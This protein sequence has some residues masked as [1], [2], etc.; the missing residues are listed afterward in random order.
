MAGSEIEIDRA[1]APPK[2]LK[3][4]IDVPCDLCGLA[5][6]EPLFSARPDESEELFD[7]VR[8]RRCDLVYLDPAPAPE[9][10]GRWYASDYYGPENTKFDGVTEKAVAFFT[11]WRGL[12]L[13]RWAPAGGK[14]LDVGCGRGNFLEVMARRGYE[15]HGTELSGLSATRARKLFGPNIHVGQLAEAEFPEKT[16][17]LTTIW[18]VLE[19]VYDPLGHL[20]ELHRVLKDD[21]RLVVAVPNFGSIQAGFGGPSWFHLD[22]PRHLF[23]FT[24]Q[25]LTRLL[26][27]AGFEPVYWSFH[28]IEQ[29]PFGLLQTV[30]NKLP[31][32]QNALYHVLKM[33]T[34]LAL[35]KGAA[36][37][38][39][40]A[41]YFL[42]PAAIVLTSLGALIRR[43][44]T[45]YVVAKKRS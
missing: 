33:E 11:W 15:V 24:P 6:A 9:D 22:V 45:F 43:G 17:D 28:S 7:V 44:G 5:D 39:K 27:A 38:L 16:F 31:L 34:P 36:L 29:N 8:C 3:S 41:Y 25:T 20:R 35:S 4:R 21:G 13:K 19:H 42:M 40:L 14:V 1:D 18:H 12:I 10:L 26:D 2:P 23:Q 37:L 32:P 30:L